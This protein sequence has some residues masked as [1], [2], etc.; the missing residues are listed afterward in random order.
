MQV[1]HVSVPHIGESQEAQGSVITVSK[2]SKTASDTWRSVA[3]ADGIRRMVA[4]LL[5]LQ[6]ALATSE[7]FITTA[8]SALSKTPANKLWYC[9]HW[10]ELL[11]PFQNG[12]QTPGMPAPTRRR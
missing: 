3:I 4:V 6:S 12:A 5:L 9:V 1:G 7:G 10:P 8:T 2:K 11:V